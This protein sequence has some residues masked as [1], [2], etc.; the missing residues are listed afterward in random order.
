MRSSRFLS[1]R[2]PNKRTVRRPRVRSRQER[3][4]CPDDIRFRFRGGDR[5]RRVVVDMG[6]GAR[7]SVDSPQ[8]RVT[9]KCRTNASRD[10]RTMRTLGGEAGGGIE[11]LAGDIE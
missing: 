3:P 9:Y 6:H 2:L 7:R 1:R 11:D 4:R 5:R 8:S 10:Y